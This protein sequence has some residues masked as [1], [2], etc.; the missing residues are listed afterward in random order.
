[1][2]GS[3][4]NYARGADLERAVATRLRE[5]GWRLVIR[6]AG[7]HGPVDVIALDP[8]AA[9]TLLIQCKGDGYLSPLER[10]ALWLLAHELDA[11]PCIADR[12][13][14]RRSLRLVTFNDANARE[15]IPWA[16]L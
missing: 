11:L 12:D 6:S 14:P 5:S 2:A 8:V 1:M 15:P 9:H 3:A 7:S 4:R 10:A 16:P 13:G